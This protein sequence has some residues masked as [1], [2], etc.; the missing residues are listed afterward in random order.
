MRTHREQW[1]RKNNLPDRSYSLEEIAKI[2]KIP[3]K[4]LEEVAKRGA[5]AYKTNPQSVRLLGSFKKNV[6]APMSQKLSKEQW[7]MGRVFSF[8]NGSLL[9]D[10]DLRK[11]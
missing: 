8:V 3:L 10:N 6:Y 4:I 1:L 9:H 2:S 11:K 5:G 7:S